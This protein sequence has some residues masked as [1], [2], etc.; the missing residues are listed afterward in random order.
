MNNT[1][2]ATGPSA[3][4]LWAHVL[5]LTGILGQMAR[6]YQPI[7]TVCVCGTTVYVPQAGCG[8]HWQAGQGD[9]AAATGAHGST[10]GAEPVNEAAQDGEAGGDFSSSARGASESASDSEVATEQADQ[11]CS[12]QGRHGG[13][14]AGPTGRTRG[15]TR[16]PARQGAPRTNWPSAQPATYVHTNQYGH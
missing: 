10:Y 12:V 9:A 13:E 4:A 11:A 3:E 1:A 15:Q 14:S 16:V 2:G 6:A 7:P 5:V 8:Q